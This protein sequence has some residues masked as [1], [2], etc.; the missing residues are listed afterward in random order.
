MAANISLADRQAVMFRQTI[1]PG[2]QKNFWRMAQDAPML[3]AIGMEKAETKRGSGS[4]MT[5]R[6]SKVQKM[7]AKYDFLVK[8]KTTRF[9]GGVR[10]AAENEALAQ[11]KPYYAESRAY[12]KFVQGSFSPT[13][14]LIITTEDDKKALANEVTENALGAAE[15]IHLEM[16]RMLVGRKEGVL[17]VINGAVSTATTV[18]VDHGGT[19]ETP[20][21]QHLH[22]GDEIWVGTV[23]QIVAGSGYVAATVASVTSDTV[24]ETTANVS[25]TDNHLVVRKNAYTAST[26]REMSG[27]SH[28]LGDTAVNPVQGV[29]R[30]S[31]NAWFVPVNTNIAGNIT[32]AAM[33]SA[34]IKARRYAQDPSALFWM[35][36]S[37]T[38]QRVTGLMTTTKQYDPTRFEGNL[39]GGVKGLTFYSPDGATPLLI[40]D[41]IEDGVMYL[42]DPNGWLYGEMAPFMFAPDALLMSGVSGQRVQGYLNYEFAFLIFGNLALLNAKS[43]IRLYGITGPAV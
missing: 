42:V 16:N 31:G 2:I 38:W 3:R 37:T 1:V 5:P 9:G 29:D 33:T 17:C 43:S 15:R 21:T 34:H 25:L 18:T 7:S 6:V 35:S 4:P 14:Q 39:A 32:L 10:A 11:G 23:E 28:L 19:A 8:H 41:M 22:P 27:L 26:W 13:I 30:S 40:D 12:A 24:F 36:N 20:P